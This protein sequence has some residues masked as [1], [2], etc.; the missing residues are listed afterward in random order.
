M[1]Q[2]YVFGIKDW[3]HCI[4]KANISVDF[5]REITAFTWRVMHVPLP[6]AAGGAVHK[7]QNCVH[8]V[9]LAA[10]RLLSRGDPVRCRHEFQ[11]PAGLH[12][13]DGSQS[14]H[15]H[16]PDHAAPLP[17]PPP[18]RHKDRFG[19]GAVIP[20]STTSRR[21]WQHVSFGSSISSLLSSRGQL[22]F[23][24]LRWR[25]NTTPMTPECTVERKLYWYLKV[26]VSDYLRG[27]LLHALGIASA[28]GRCSCLLLVIHSITPSPQRPK[29]PGSTCG[30]KRAARAR[31]RDGGGRK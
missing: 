4:L 24:V 14:P 22:V 13:S 31:W 8:P 11:C 17:P 18:R 9:C 10:A 6:F 29:L 27:P 3:Q 30:L 1:F 2:G 5:K 28:V 16:A 25:Y 19:Y 23:L 15:P 26:W 20:Y 7:I 21:H 12:S